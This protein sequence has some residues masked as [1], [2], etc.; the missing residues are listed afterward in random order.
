MATEHAAVE[1]RAEHHLGGLM[2]EAVGEAEEPAESGAVRQL[3]P[4]VAPPAVEARGRVADVQ[5]RDHAEI[6]GG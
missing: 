2:T 5:D 6:G 3:P 1:H 4:G